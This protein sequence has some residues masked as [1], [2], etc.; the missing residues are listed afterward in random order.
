MTNIAIL[1]P[2]RMGA[3]VAAQA[4]RT[5]THVR[6]C[7]AGR[8]QATRERADTYGLE[9]IDILPKLM[10]GSDVTISLCPPSAADDVA[11]SVA[12]SG[13]RG[14]YV[15]ANAITPERAQRIADDLGQH[16]ITVVD[17][18]IFGA[19]P[20]PDSTV[21]LY[22]AGDPAGVRTISDLFTGSQVE[23][24]A[25]NG[26][27]GQASAIKLAQASYQKASRALA[28]VAYA[29]AD[30]Y[31]VRDELQQESQN[32]AR[33]ALTAPNYLPS[34]AARAWRWAPEMAETASA[35]H[36]A[37][38]PDDLARGA[39]TVFKLMAQAKD[40]YNIP[41]EDVLAMLTPGQSD[42]TAP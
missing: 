41:L 13:F 29:L 40:D 12:D 30:H 36:T 17:G 22:L 15:E 34:V 2:G 23:P 28:A 37:G 24:V 27:V 6:W 33:S 10:A 1:H 25:M 7:P 21:R 5:D 42:E 18:C 39:E 11:R 9:P 35:L 19:P 3:A 26:S 16:G 31:G 8:S 4:I 32:F 20:G 14:L 38:L